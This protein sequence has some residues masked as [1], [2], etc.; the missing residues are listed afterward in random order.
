MD[1]SLIAREEAYDAQPI[2]QV[3]PAYHSS[4]AWGLWYGYAVGL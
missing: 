3:Q 4:R 2:M 1:E